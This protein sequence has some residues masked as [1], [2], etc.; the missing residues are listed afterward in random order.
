[1]PTVSTCQLHLIEYN[2]QVMYAN[3]DCLLQPL[4]RTCQN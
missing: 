2:Y 3:S 4:L 1:M